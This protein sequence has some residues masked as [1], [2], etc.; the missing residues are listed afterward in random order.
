MGRNAHHLRQRHHL[1]TGDVS[2]ETS[3]TRKYK[4][5]YTKE[6]SDKKWPYLHGKMDNCAKFLFIAFP[7]LVIY[8]IYT[9]WLSA[10]LRNMVNTR[11][12]VSQIIPSNA[13]SAQ[14]DP[15]RFWG[16][17]RPGVY[18][19]LKTRSPHSPVV[20]K[21]TAL[22]DMCKVKYLLLFSLQGLTMTVT[23]KC[24]ATCTPSK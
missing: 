24:L 21:L 8:G 7:S 5:D 16:S 13:S 3:L 11:L 6:Y 1:N 23:L 9:V 17:Y 2:D 14:V 4:Y 10:M 18:F 15:E 22:L 19:G 12:P 20:G